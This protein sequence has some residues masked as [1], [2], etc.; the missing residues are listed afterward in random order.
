VSTLALPV[1]GTAV[2]HRP[3]ARPHRASRSAY[4]RRRA[5]AVAVLVLLAFVL[6]VAIGRVGAEAELA[7]KVA[8]HVVIE[9]GAT[10]WDVAVATAPDGVDPRQQLA[11]L[12]ELNGLTGSQVRAWSVVLVPAR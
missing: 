7:D 1:A 3:A 2:A 8:G 12:R 11:D 4:H 5:V 10:L 6:T 9:P